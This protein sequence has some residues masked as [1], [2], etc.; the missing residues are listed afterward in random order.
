AVTVP[1]ALGGFDQPLDLALG[2]VA[3][4]NCEVFSAWCAGIGC[5]IYHWNSLL[6]IGNWN[7][8]S[9]FLHSLKCIYLLPHKKHKRFSRIFSR[10][11]FSFVSETG[12]GAY[13]PPPVGEG[14]DG[15]WSLC[16]SSTHARNPAMG[17]ERNWVPI[18]AS[19]WDPNPRLGPGADRGP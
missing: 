4:L 16:G 19:I 18:C 17:P 12:S 15:S 2:E 8:Y 5:L 1:V 14:A 10:K 11:I 3:T 13:P 7:Q 6:D 9:L